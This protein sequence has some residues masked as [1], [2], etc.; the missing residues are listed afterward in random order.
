MVNSSIQLF[1]L[2]QVVSPGLLQ[3]HDFCGKRQASQLHRCKGTQQRSRQI[4]QGSRAGGEHGPGRA[5]RREW[6]LSDPLSSNGPPSNLDLPRPGPRPCWCN[7]RDQGLGNRTLFWDCV[8][9][10]DIVK[11]MMRHGRFRPPRPLRAPG[12]SPCCHKA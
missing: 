8:C 1:L 3:R 9:W 2:H 11:N 5:H 6:W 7:Q 4:Q 12:Q 10:C